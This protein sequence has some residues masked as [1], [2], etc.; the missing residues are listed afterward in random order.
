MDSNAEGIKKDKDLGSRHGGKTI[1]D[2]QKIKLEPTE[3]SKIITNG[4]VSPMRKDPDKADWD[5]MES[6]VM[7][8]IKLSAHTQ[9]TVA[10]VAPSVVSDL[11]NDNKPN[12][13]KVGTLHLRRGFSK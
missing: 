10:T 12:T 7:E 4:P 9:G 6:E 1:I 13:N 3:G 8:M 11:T 5:K 2:N